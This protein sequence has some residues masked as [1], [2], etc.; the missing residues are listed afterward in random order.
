MIKIAPRL[1]DEYNI[2]FEDKS[3]A[4][5]DGTNPSFVRTLEGMLD[6]DPEYEK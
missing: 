1:L 5:V 2:T 3:R 4:F 6:E